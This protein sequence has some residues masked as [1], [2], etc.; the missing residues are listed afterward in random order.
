MRLPGPR[1]PGLVIE[2]TGSVR[3]SR[4]GRRVSRSLEACTG[5]GFLPRA[6]RRVLAGLA[7]AGLAIVLLPSTGTSADIR[8]APAQAPPP[9]QALVPVRAQA[10]AQAAS[11]RPL[12]G[13]IVGIDPG[14]NG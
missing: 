3:P 4:Q 8:P 9:A 13:K 11:R 2:K 7:A 10:P 14:H 1:L 12:A 5:M 6:S